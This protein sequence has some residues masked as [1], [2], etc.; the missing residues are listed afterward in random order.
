MTIRIRKPPKGIWQLGDIASFGGVIGRIVVMDMNSGWP[1]FWVSTDP[2]VQYG[3]GRKGMLVK[4]DLAGK[5]QSWHKEPLLSFVRRPTKKELATL[6]QEQTKATVLT[7][8]PNEEK[9]NE[10]S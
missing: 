10:Q 6:T 8:L 4:F 7:I 3:A 1:L 5:F 2:D 9:S